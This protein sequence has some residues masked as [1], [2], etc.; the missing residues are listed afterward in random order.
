[1]NKTLPLLLFTALFLTSAAQNLTQQWATSFAGTG[2][3]SDKFN[4]LAKDNAGN[5]YACGYT[6][7]SGNGK[8]FLLVKFNAAG[9]TLWTRTYDNTGNGND[10]LTDV[11]IDASGNVAVTGSGKTGTG[12][13]IITALYSSAGTLLWLNSYNGY[14]N[15]DDYGVKVASDNAGNI[16][17]AGY[18]YNAALNNDY[19]VIK[20]A[21]NGTQSAAV[22]FNG[23]DALEDI[24]ADM[25]IDGA[26]NVIVTGKSRTSGNKDDYATIKYNSSLVLQWA[27][28][29]DQ[30][31]KTDRATG[32][33]VDAAN[34]VY[35]TGR[36]SNGGDDDYLTIKYAAANGATAWAQ[37]KL[38]D[39]NGDD[40]A[41]DITGNA[42][43]IVVTGTRFN[44]VQTDIQTIAYNPATGAQLWSTTYANAA[45][46]DDIAN[47]VTLS[48]ANEAIVTGVVNLS[49]S[50]ISQN[51]VLILKYN[52]SGAQQFAAVLGGTATLDDNAAASLTDG[53]GN[54]YTAATLVNN[55]TM[56]DAVLLAHDAAGALQYNK[57]YNGKGEF[58]DKAI[59][60]C[61]SGGFVYTTGYTYAY[62]EDRNFCTIKYDAAG[63]KLWTKTFNGPDTDTDEPSAIAADGSGNI[64]VA[65]RSKNANNDY[66]LFLIKYNAAGDTLWTR[67]YDAGITGDDE[68]TAMAVATNGDVYLTGT[69]D[70]DASLLINSDYLTV[71]FSA[72][73]TLLWSKTYNGTTNADDKA[74][75]ITLDNTG[76]A[77]VAGRTFNGADYDIQINKY[78]AANGTAT[79]FATYNSNLGDDIPARIKLDNSGNVVVGATSDRNATA[80]TNRDYLL[81][82]Y[83]SAGSQ[84]W[85]QLYN[86]AATGDDDLND[87]IIDANNNIYITGT[88]DLD[89]SATDNLDYATLMYNSS[90]TLQWLATYN[91]TGNGDDIA[92]A[93]ATDGNGN[94]YVTGISD[95]GT[96]NNAVT[97]MYDAQGNL[98][99]QASFDGQAGGYDAGE[100]ILVD[101]GSVYIAG[102]GTF[103]SANQKDLLTVAYNLGLAIKEAE[104]TTLSIYPNPCTNNF[105][106]AAT[107]NQTSGVAIYNSLGQTIYTTKITGLSSIATA[108]WAPGMYTVQLQNQDGIKVT[109]LIIQ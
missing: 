74:Y 33:W 49:A 81:I 68:A 104:A 50:A 31:G 79:A 88:S 91:G 58:T 86:G 7:Q 77:Y 46:K 55:T 52:S 89:S 42:T 1:M 94:L 92:N 36:S 103:S 18:G 37:P 82:N 87:L 85:A 105:W 80:A 67:N 48:A 17:T 6:W 83:N 26:N 102:A 35:V 66:D 12:K 109:R 5:L 62:N 4:A 59:A 43:N 9:D 40:Q 45:G 63:N 54:I 23:A 34:D 75:S 70:A 73:G 10:E 57:A 41:R 13:D 76:N 65:G 44:G 99:A 84:Q 61:P 56:K 108:N 38:F 97:L 15:L 72:A 64:Y 25:A 19:I 106:I 93:L 24:V 107:G 69:T 32:V 47:Q 53:Q 3:N 101:N 30:A 27:K 60:I 2:E 78:A 100:A 16:Y 71:K 11:A 21:A 98:A 90:G 22:N 96:S 28:T 95:N 20:Y 51:D 14:A 29:V 39:S 8:D